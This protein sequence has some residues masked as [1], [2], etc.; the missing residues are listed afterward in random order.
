[1][2]NIYEFSWSYDESYQK[3]INDQGETPITADC[4]FDLLYQGIPGE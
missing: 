1:M 2:S 3:Y 4:K